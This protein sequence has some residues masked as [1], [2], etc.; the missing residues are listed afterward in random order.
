MK[1]ANAGKYHLQD[2]QALKHLSSLYKAFINPEYRVCNYCMNISQKN[3]TEKLKIGIDAR[4]LSRPLTGIGRYTLEMC[5][6]LNKTGIFNLYLY[7]PAP[8]NS[9]HLKYLD[10]SSFRIQGFDNIV[11]RQV[12]AGLYLPLMARRDEIDLFWGPAHR[13]PRLLPSNI[14]KIVTIHDLV[15]KYFGETM[16]PASRLLEKYQ[17]PNSIRSSHHII[18]VSQSTATAVLK[19]Y[20]VEPSKINVVYPAATL[21]PDVPPFSK[22]SELGIDKPFYL[23][24]GTPEPRKNICRLLKAHAG[25]S[26]NLKE[27]AMLVIAGGHGWGDLQLAKVI[28]DLDISSSVLVTGYVD[29]TVLAALYANTMFLAMPSLYEGF[30]LP[31]IEA[32][33]RGK[34]VLTSNNS[35]MPEVAG[36]SGLLVDALSVN[37]ILCGL[38]KLI[39]DKKLRQK[40]AANALRNAQRYDWGKSAG[41]LA[42]IF[43]RT[44]AAVNSQQ[45]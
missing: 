6:A 44:V 5:R 19:E 37:S 45:K 21:R 11:H 13:L 28:E 1:W 16:R 29:E 10:G 22:L 41:Q 26:T 3:K 9:E 12:W 35:S 17:M 24:V 43:A 36:N 32:M 30:G 15:W 38:E 18:T 20:E 34:P 7:S 27:K 14:A 31:I 2:K 25:L 8:I 4:I 33:S 40:L 42:K 39:D 23:F